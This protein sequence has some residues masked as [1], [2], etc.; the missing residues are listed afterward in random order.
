M[1]QNTDEHSYPKGIVLFIIIGTATCGSIL[2]LI[3]STI[4]N[5]ALRQMAGGLGTSTIDIAWVI[6]SYAISNVIIIPLSGMLA[7]VF[8]RKLYYT[9]SIGIFTFASLMC[10][11]SH[12]LW[13]IVLW[14]ILQGIG[15]GALMATS[16][17][18]IMEAFPPKKIGIAMGIYG[19]A[20][21][22]GPAI[23]PFVGGY[24]TDHFSWHL[25]F[26]VNIPLG[27]AATILSWFFIENS[28]HE[29]KFKRLDLW[30]ILW[31]VIAIGSLQFVLEEGNRY[32]WFES[33][34]ICAFALVSAIAFVLF[35]IQELHTPEPAIDIRLFSRRNFSLGIIMTTLL[36]AILVG[37]IYIYPLFTQVELGW[38][39]QLSGLSIMPGTLLTAV[40]IGLTQR[41][42]QK[43]VSP[44]FFV[45]L[46]FSLTA[47]YCLM[48]TLQ[49]TDSS[50]T[51]LFI[52][53]LLRGFALGL[54]IAPILRLS[55]DGLTGYQLAQ[56]NGVTNMARQLGAAVGVALLNV[57]ITHFVA[58]SRSDL[59]SNLTPT[60]TGTNQTISAMTST[61]GTNGFSSD[62]AL[63]TAYKILDLS[64]LKQSTLLSYLD[65]FYMIGIACIVVIPLIFFMKKIQRVS[66]DQG[67]MEMI[68]E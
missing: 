11:V 44:K 59:V 48:M 37:A 53:M 16:Q 60:S 33:N 19:M 34:L 24:L 20:I 39:A 25:I 46:G 35:I 45:T 31:L 43:G 27:A 13:E 29:K 32:D 9:M 6:T 42:I 49:S 66:P 58:Q 54:C 63:T 61:L 50:M 36:G 14:R 47:L 8:G 28:V 1:K 21:S 68:S 57:R 56:G 41:F 15:G 17:T 3:D 67:Q 62:H 55:I 12:S 23:G 18:I 38:T 30:G 5:V 22:M 52:P 64:I 7:S 26:L 10:G 4:V 2:Q 65:A 51:S 40:G